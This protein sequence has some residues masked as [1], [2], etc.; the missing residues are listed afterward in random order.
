MRSLQGA[1]KS[2]GV[3]HP[4]FDST[5]IYIILVDVSQQIITQYSYKLNVCQTTNNGNDSDAE[6]NECLK[7]TSRRMTRLE[8]YDS[9]YSSDRQT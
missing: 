4:C 5:A 1:V 9:N 7:Y 3:H 8:E 2:K 6:R